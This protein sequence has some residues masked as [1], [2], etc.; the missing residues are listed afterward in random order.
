MIRSLAAQD[1]ASAC[2]AVD[3]EFASASGHT[4]DFRKL[5]FT[6]SCLALSIKKNSVKTKPASSLVVSLEKALKGIPPSC[7]V[8]RWQATVTF[9]NIPKKKRK[10]KIQSDCKNL[11]FPKVERGSC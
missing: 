7:V 5:V 9:I 11:V 10:Y 2:E 6:A 1:G 4:K 3:P 8:E